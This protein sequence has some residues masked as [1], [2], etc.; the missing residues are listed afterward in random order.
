MSLEL[1]RAACD[2]RD[3]GIVGGRRD[4]HENPT[5]LAYGHYG[6]VNLHFTSK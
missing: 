1:L 4:L 5:Y 3:S 2:S 6:D